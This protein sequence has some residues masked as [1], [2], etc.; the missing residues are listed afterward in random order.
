MLRW[1]MLGYESWQRKR[2]RHIEKQATLERMA[3]RV[4]K[5]CSLVAREPQDRCSAADEFLDGHSRDEKICVAL[6]QEPLLFAAKQLGITLPEDC[7][8]MS[9]SPDDP[10]L[11]QYQ[12]WMLRG[13][14]RK[15]RW[16]RVLNWPSLVLPVVSAI[17]FRGCHERHSPAQRHSVTNH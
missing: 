2:L 4:S 13:A 8:A 12:E 9:I 6:S 10:T 5:F 1:L 17:I 14:I 16:K 3:Q 11:T 15:Q 7:R